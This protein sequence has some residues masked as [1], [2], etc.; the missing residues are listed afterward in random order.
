MRGFLVAAIVTA[1]GI[2]A[3]GTTSEGDVAN[4]LAAGRGATDCARWATREFFEAAVPKDITACVWVGSDPNTQ[5]RKGRTPLH[6][7]AWLNENA[8]VTEELLAAGADPRAEDDDGWTPLQMAARYNRNAAVTQQIIAA[9]AVPNTALSYAAANRSVAVTEMLLA[10][11]VDANAKGDGGWAPLHIAAVDQNAVVVQALVAAGADP[12]ARTDY[13]WTPLH[14]ASGFCPREVRENDYA[15]PLEAA[16]TEVLMPQVPIPTRAANSVRQRR[17]T[18]QPEATQ[19]QRCS[20]RSLLRAR[21]PVP[22]TATDRPPC[23][24]R[25]DTTRY[26]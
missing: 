14:C 3:A 15:I 21:I 22:R 4:P 6:L 12:N 17:C 7:A 20:R 10:L 9:G 11:G 18:T 16:V 5:L 13:G 26:P 23:I 19:T 25:R 2:L 1:P 24:G 8:S